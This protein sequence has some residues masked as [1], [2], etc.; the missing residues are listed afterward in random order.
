MPIHQYKNKNLYDLDDFEFVQ[1]PNDNGDSW[2][3]MYNYMRCPQ[4]DSDF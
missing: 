3:D 1:E 2:R 4:P